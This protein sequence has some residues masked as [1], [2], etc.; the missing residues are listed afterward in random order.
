MRWLR[1]TCLTALVWLA[2]AM[3]VVAGVP[4]FTCHCPDGRVKTVCLGSTTAQKG[5]CCCDGAC[6]GEKAESACCKKSGSDSRTAAGCCGHHGESAPNAP[7]KAQPSLAV[8]CCTRTLVQPE[9]S[10]FLSSERVVVKDVTLGALLGVQHAPLWTAPTEPC[11]FRQ[12]HQRPPP[13]DLL[14]TLQRLL[15]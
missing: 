8:P 9:V 13:T 4:H 5:V 15:I 7:A 11:A 1:K 3:T 2:A 6:C 10:T 12:D 14:T